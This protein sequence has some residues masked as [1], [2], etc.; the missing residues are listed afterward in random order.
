ML[1]LNRSE[2]WIIISSGASEQDYLVLA[3]YKLALLEDASSHIV[4]ITELYL[5][6]LF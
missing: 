6:I 1:D 3:L 2:S 4:R 5:L